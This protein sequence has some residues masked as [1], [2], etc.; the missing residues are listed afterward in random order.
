MRDHYFII[1]LFNNDCVVPLKK[2]K[3]VCVEDYN[4]IE[5]KRG[6]FG[7][8][9]HMYMK[10]YHNKNIVPSIDRNILFP[11]ILWMAEIHSC[12]IILFVIVQVYMTVKSGNLK[13]PRTY[14]ETWM[15]S[16][17]FSMLT[18]SKVFIGGSKEPF[19]LPGSSSKNNF[20]GCLR[21][22]STKYK[23]FSILIRNINR[24]K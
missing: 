17:T 14:N 10:C 12:L 8:L 2:D 24:H 16:G 5:S 21:N 1:S 18:S 7:K 6:V 23:H 13:D 15:T 22:V 3:I 9:Q 4:S 11:T 20:V 19:R